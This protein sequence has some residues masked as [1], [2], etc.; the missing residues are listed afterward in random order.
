MSKSFATVDL[1]T[2][3][4]CIGYQVGSMHAW[5]ADQESVL[6]V[7][8][9]PTILGSK[10]FR[11]HAHTFMELVLLDTGVQFSELVSHCHIDKECW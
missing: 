11:E 2:L 6:Q 5:R 4:E 10:R 8:W 7:L 3:W 9:P 1:K